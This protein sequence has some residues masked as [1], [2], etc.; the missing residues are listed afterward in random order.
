[1]HPFVGEFNDKDLQDILS[2]GDREPATEPVEEGAAL[3]QAVD[4]LLDN[5][6]VGD[7]VDEDSEG[8]SEMQCSGSGVEERVS[9]KKYIEHIE[10]RLKFL[11]NLVR[12]KENEA[13]RD[14]LSK[15]RGSAA[16]EK[17][18]MEDMG[19]SEKKQETVHTKPRKQ[20]QAANSILSIAGGPFRRLIDVRRGRL[21]KS[22]RCQ[23]E[24]G[25][26]WIRR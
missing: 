19:E 15:L 2:E 8:D 20:L 25:M 4:L 9:L 10:E 18:F 6:E 23:P 14:M 3:S 11:G 24:S 1:M 21:D 16:G 12:F 22:T 26:A 13:G 17:A 5:L 7:Q